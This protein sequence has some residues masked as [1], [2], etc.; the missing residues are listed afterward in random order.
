MSEI[1][2]LD[3]TDLV[4]V[5]RLRRDFR[6]AKDALATATALAAEQAGEIERLR[7]LVEEACEIAADL[8]EAP[9]DAWRGEVERTSTRNRIEEIDAIA[10]GVET[11][12]AKGMP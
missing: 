12:A 9:N 10:R 11:T 1:A 7:A 6:K 5:N 2:S 4:W 8:N 3:Y